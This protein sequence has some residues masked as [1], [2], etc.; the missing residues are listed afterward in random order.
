MSENGWPVLSSKLRFKS[1]DES[2]LIADEIRMFTPC[3]WK[4]QSQRILQGEK[5]NNLSPRSRQTLMDGF[6]S[7][8]PLV[9]WSEGLKQK[10][11][12]VVSG[13]KGYFWTCLARW[14]DCEITIKRDCQLQTHVFKSL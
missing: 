6:L 7:F 2:R 13:F 14:L 4:M 9:A 3:L 11:R 12:S 5:V 8:S 1:V 10:L